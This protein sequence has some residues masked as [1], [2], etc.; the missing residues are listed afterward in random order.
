MVTNVI[1]YFGHTCYSCHKDISET[2]ERSYFNYYEN[3]KLKFLKKTP[4]WDTKKVTS[5][6][7]TQTY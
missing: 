6:T 2:V 3:Y 4:I 1:I 7:T 5:K